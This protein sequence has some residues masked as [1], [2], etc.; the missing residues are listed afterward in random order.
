MIILSTVKE[1]ISSKRTVL[2]MEIKEICSKIDHTLL[3]PTA[4]ELDI[5]KLCEQGKKYSVASVCV[6]PCYVKTAYARAGAIPVCTVIGFP[7][8]YNTT[9][10]KVYETQRAIEEGA[11]EIDMVINIGRLKAGDY[12]YVGKEIEAVREACPDKILKVIIET[13]YLN[14]FEK[15][16]MCHLIAQMG[17]DFIKTSTGFG[18]AG[19]TK[20]DVAFLASI[21]SP[22]LKIKA[23]GGISTF[24]DA[25]EFLLLGAHRLGCSRLINL[26]EQQQ[27]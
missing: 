15:K 24:D 8:G 20:E 11:S 25:R 13:C 2:I 16:Q 14:T 23:S 12:N 22:Y 6:P 26:L 10:S 17:A 7:N 18:N 21:C 1:R 9:A 3:S 4:T 19:A 5:I 27:N